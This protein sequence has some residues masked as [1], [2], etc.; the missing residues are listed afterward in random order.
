MASKCNAD[1]PRNGFL[2]ESRN[3]KHVNVMAHARAVEEMQGVASRSR[4]RVSSNNGQGLIER[5]EMK[6]R[7]MCRRQQY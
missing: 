1:E 6:K 3:P 4:K 7:V 5:H 2:T